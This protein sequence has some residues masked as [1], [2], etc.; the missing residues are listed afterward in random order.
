M[1]SRT[2]NACLIAALALLSGPPLFAAPG[3]IAG[4]FVDADAAT[5]RISVQ[6][7]CT[8]EYLGHDPEGQ[9][10]FLRVRLE[11]TRVC[12][13]A[14]PTIADH[15]E[16]HR[17]IGAD[18]AKLISLEYNGDSPAGRILRLDFSQDVWVDRVL[19]VSDNTITIHVTLD[20]GTPV[21]A[22]PREVTASRL[23]RTPDVAAPRYVINLESSQRRPATADL[24]DVSIEGDQEL[25]VSQADI[26]GQTWYRTRI[27]YF[28]SAN[29]ASGALRKL[30]AQFPTAWIDMVSDTQSVARIEMSAVPEAVPLPG[31]KE[32][33]ASSAPADDRSSRLMEDARR[34]MITG[35]LSRAIQIYTKVLQLPP[36]ALQQDAQEYLALAR[37]RNGQLAHAKAEYERYLA[38]YPGSE[39]AERVN[40]RLAALLASSA[41]DAP[42]AASNAAASRP[43]PSNAAWSVRTFASQFYRRDVNQMNDQAEVVGQSS[44][45]TDLSVDARRRGQE[46]EPE[47]AGLDRGLSP[48]GDDRPRRAVRRHRPALPHGE[49]EDPSRVRARARVRVRIGSRMQGSGYRAPSHPTCPQITQIDAD[50]LATAKPSGEAG[51]THWI[52]RTHRSTQIRFFNGEAL[53]RGAHLPGI[54]ISSF[55][56]WRLCVE[57][58]N[59]PY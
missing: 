26:D 57:L 20:P 12:T 22:A 56:P 2:R 9:G 16:Q 13:G 34:A 10:D 59:T 27:G 24:P 7:R 58:L 29:A 23:V 47:V 11:S 44:I 14:S 49:R 19:T 45:Y 28:D 21:A 35:E 40:Q 55:A 6:F 50:P 36:S 43:R 42:S 4:S 41:P 18:A 46:I 5:A 31:A 48:D 53:G 17:P 3:F 30:R 33:A 1:T 39:G 51:P 32:A 8:V 37:E 25:F 15:R 54:D 38:I 52:H